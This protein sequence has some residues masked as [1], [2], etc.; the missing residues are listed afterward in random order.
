MHKYLADITSF[1]KKSPLIVVGIAS[2][3]SFVVF[4]ITVPRWFA[5]YVDN[6]FFMIFAFILTVVLYRINPVLGVVYALFAFELLRRS[7]NMNYLAPRYTIDM[8][9][10][11]KDRD[12]KV[13][14]EE[15]HAYTLEQEM[16]ELMKRKQPEG[17][18]LD[19]RPIATNYGNASSL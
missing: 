6:S 12:L 4:P 11:D 9:Q 17:Y 10:R 19:A 13:M 18:N 1:T 7:T 3:L 8:S 2:L 15:T 5:P 14:N 16:V